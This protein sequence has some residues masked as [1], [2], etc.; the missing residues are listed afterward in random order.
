MSELLHWYEAFGEFFVKSSMF[1]FSTPCSFSS[2]RS[3][4]QSYSFNLLQAR[5]EVSRI[6]CKTQVDLILQKLSTRSRGRDG[7]R[8]DEGTWRNLA[9][10]PTLGNCPNQHI[11]HIRYVS[12]VK[13]KEQIS[14]SRKGFAT[15]ART[16]C[17]KKEMLLTAL[18]QLKKIIV[19]GTW[20]YAA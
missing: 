14:T 9:G 12:R 20:L 1:C 5:I 19:Y 4:D 17:C 11:Q 7:H 13:L 6:G 3:F 15:T 18:A 10:R 8:K 16:S 2:R